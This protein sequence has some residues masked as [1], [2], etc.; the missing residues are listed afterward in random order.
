MH[1]IVLLTSNE[2]VLSKFQMHVIQIINDLIQDSLP[3][4]GTKL[5]IKI[6]EKVI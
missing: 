3:R 1:P 2:I 4:M 5:K 6:K